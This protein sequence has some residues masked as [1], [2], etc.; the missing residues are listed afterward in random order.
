MHVLILA[1]AAALRAATPTPAHEGPNAN[2]HICS[3]LSDQIEAGQRQLSSIDA[4]GV[5]DDSAARAQMRA[6]RQ[7][8]EMERIRA[9]ID[10]M[11]AHRCAPY[12]HPI[13]THR[14]AV[15]ALRC[16]TDLIGAK[17]VPDSCDGSKWEPTDF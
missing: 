14:Y 7:I 5:G 13:S 12:A 16:Q 17:S 3:A 6:A 9:N 10:L 8:T 11:A 4:Q 2:V 15:P 1:A